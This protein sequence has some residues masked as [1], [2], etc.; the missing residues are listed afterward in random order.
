[1]MAISQVSSD[2]AIAMAKDLALKDGLMAGISSGAAARAAITVASRPENAG[3]P[4]GF[5]IGF[6]IG[7][8]RGFS[9]GFSIGFSMGLLSLP[10]RERRRAGAP[11]SIGASIGVSDFFFRPE[12]C[13]A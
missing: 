6:S 10:P 1:M 9:I 5:S 12:M 4:T 13:P 8:S 7:F 2:E 3:A 11:G